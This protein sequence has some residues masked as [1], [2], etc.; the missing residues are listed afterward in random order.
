MALEQKDVDRVK[1]DLDSVAEAFRHSADLRAFLESPAVSHDLKHKVV[2]ELA[3]RMDLVPAVRNFV[4]LLVDHHRTELLGEIEQA[5][6]TELN[7]RLGVAHA[8]VTSARELSDQ[9]R[10]EL[11]R[12]LEQRTG[13]RIEARFRRD[14]SLV[15][16][17]VVRVGSTIYNGSVREQLMRLR[18][19]LETE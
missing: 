12:A 19:Q 15:G 18:Q 6:E 14:P 1:R 8:E 2:G 10:R 17:T 11:T 4:F 7:A 3:S 13:K 9:E 5:L 16:G